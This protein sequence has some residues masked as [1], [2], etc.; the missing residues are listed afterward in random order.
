MTEASAATSHASVIIRQWGRIPVTVRAIVSGLFV[1]AILQFGWWPSFLSQ[2]FVVLN[3]RTSPDIPWNVPLGLLY[4]WVVFQFF[5]GRWG[6]GSTREARQKSM[7]ARRLTCQEWKSAIGAGTVVMVFVISFLMLT[8]RLIEVPYD[9][10]DL[11]ALP[12]WTQ[13]STLV[14]IS[15]VASV[16]EEAGF[17]GY[18]QAPLEERH[19][20]VVAIGIS[21][22]LFWLIHLNDPSG[23]VMLPALLVIGIAFGAFAYCARSILPV[24]VVHVAVDIVLLVGPATEIG[25]SSFWEPPLLWDAGVDAGFYATLAVTAASGI[26][27]VFVLRSLAVLTRPTAPAQ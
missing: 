16:S 9:G 23:F 12:W 4:L 22:V 7:R 19:G 24:I 10:I 26:A 27:A 1:W 8:Q 20:P 2:A 25:P 5:N 14:M 17:R 11:S 15:I 18:I 6:A 21:A 13:Y 3:M